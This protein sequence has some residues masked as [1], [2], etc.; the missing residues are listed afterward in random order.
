MFRSSQL[1]IAY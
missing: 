1:H